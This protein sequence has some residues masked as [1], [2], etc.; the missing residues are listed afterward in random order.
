[1]ALSGIRNKASAKHIRATPSC[2]ESE[3]KGFSYSYDMLGEAAL[4]EKDAQDYLVSS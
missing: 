3:E 4:T 2:E 1:M